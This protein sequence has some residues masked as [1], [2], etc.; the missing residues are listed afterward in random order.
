[1]PYTQKFTRNFQYSGWSAITLAYGSCTVFSGKIFIVD[2]F[3]SRLLDVRIDLCR[4][5]TDMT[6]HHLNRTKI[7]AMVQ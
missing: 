5:D 6:E 1:M 3:Q 2:S 7:G 4:G